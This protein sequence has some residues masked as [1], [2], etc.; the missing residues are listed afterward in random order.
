MPYPKISPVILL[1][2]V[3]AGYIAYN[4]VLDRLHHLNPIA[5]LLAELCDGSRSIEDIHHEKCVHRHTRRSAS[6]E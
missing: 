4:P 1:S 2:P 6:S 3:E 5:A